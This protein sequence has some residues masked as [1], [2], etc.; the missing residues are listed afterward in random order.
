MK[1]T[2]QLTA[3]LHRWRDGDDSARSEL[4]ELV[5]PE[6]QRLAR[7]RLRPERADHTLSST[8]LVHEAYLRLAGADVPWNSRAHFFAV[9]AQMMRRILVDYAKQRRRKKRG[10]SRVRVTLKEALLGGEEAEPMVEDL[11]EAINRLAELNDRMAR[12]V[13]LHFFGGLT[14]A[15]TAEVLKMSSTTVNRELRFA[16]AWLRDQLIQTSTHDE[17]SRSQRSQERNRDKE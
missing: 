2:R 9:A 15:E 4:V 12:V 13:E 3:L 6:L 14:Y 5:Y 16:K 8:D 10:G 17:E 1:T 11:D 7:Q